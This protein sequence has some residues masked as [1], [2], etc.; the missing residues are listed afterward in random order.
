M[1]SW[2]VKTI[3]DVAKFFGMSTAGIAQWRQEEMPGQKNHWDLSEIT[4]WR[5]ERMRRALDKR[6]DAAKDD[7]KFEL[8]RMRAEIMRRR[9]A[10]EDGT[11]LPF[12]EHEEQILELLSSVREDLLSLAPTLA[13]QTGSPDERARFIVI[14]DRLN[15][16]LSQLARRG[17]DAILRARRAQEAGAPA[18]GPAEGAAAAEN[19]AGARRGRPPGRP[20]SDEDDEEG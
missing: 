19:G 2:V 14:E 7:P 5:L 8:S 12:E 15:D 1:P 10:A 11:S 13:A 6:G 3:K 4:Q 17:E 16:F 20:R 18:A 9:M